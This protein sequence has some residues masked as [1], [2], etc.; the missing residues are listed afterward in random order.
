MENPNM[1]TSDKT[2]KELTNI[3]GFGDRAVI[4]EL[5]DRLK[6]TSVIPGSANYTQ[7][8]S[9]LL[10][11]VAVAHGLDPFNGEVWLIKDKDGKVRGIMIGIKGLRKAAKNQLNGRQYWTRIRLL[12]GDDRK[13]I[14]GANNTAIVYRCELSDQDTSGAYLAL[15]AQAIA[16]GKTKD[17]VTAEMGPMPATVGI[18][19]YD[20]A[21]EYSKMTPHQAAMKR[22]EA[23]AIKRRF[24]VPFGMMFTEADN[25]IDVI[26]MDQD[27]VG[28]GGP[29]ITV[30]DEPGDAPT[31]EGTMQELGFEASRPWS[32]EY[33][34]EVV[35]AKAKTTITNKTPNMQGTVISMIEFAFMELPPADREKIRHSIT[36]YLI[37][38]S[39]MKDAT[40]G[41]VRALLDWM[42]PVED[43][44]GAVTISDIV[45]QELQGIW[46]AAQV[47]AGQLELPV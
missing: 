13:S 2:G 34:R 19:I 40:G 11:Q 38:R 44:G 42:A 4:R 21:S 29:D 3:P 18:G 41:E 10:A 8:E 25:P 37:K 5:A 1:K 15:Y 36:E 27:E 45:V 46:K 16:A 14:V 24:D 22:A 30:Q 17:E 28:E 33:I 20:P 35:Q 39:S 7:A 9:V 32:A 43:N 12:E 6:M 23:D 47:A 26:P 31:I